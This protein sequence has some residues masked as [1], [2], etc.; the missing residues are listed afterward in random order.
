MCVSKL[1]IRSC[2]HLQHKLV[3]ANGEMNG[4]NDGVI[5]HKHVHLLLGYRQGVFL[6]K[7][8]ACRASKDAG[9]RTVCI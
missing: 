1:A 8:A 6:P 2:D 7:G 5:I 3:T 4:W 9:E